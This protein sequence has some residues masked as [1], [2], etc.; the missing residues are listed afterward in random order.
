MGESRK[1]LR[2]VDDPVGRTLWM[3]KHL[4][5]ESTVAYLA[6]IASTADKL[7]MLST[8]DKAR[9]ADLLARVPAKR[10]DRAA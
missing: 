1:F 8:Q 4:P 2:L 3:L 10:L 7:G 6:M 9:I 5:L